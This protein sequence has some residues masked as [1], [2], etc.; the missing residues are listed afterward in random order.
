MDRREMQNRCLARLAT[1]LNRLGSGGAEV[2]F[3]TARAALQQI[4]EDLL[5]PLRRESAQIL[6]L[7]RESV[8]L[9][10]DIVDSRGI[11]A[12]CYALVTPALGAAALQGLLEAV[13]QHRGKRSEMLQRFSQEFCQKVGEHPCLHL[14]WNAWM[15]WTEEHDDDTSSLPWLLYYAWRGAGTELLELDGLQPLEELRRAAGASSA[16]NVFTAVRRAVRQQQLLA[17]VAESVARKT[18]RT[19]EGS[20]CCCIWEHREKT[21]PNG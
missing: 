6:E 19:A 2:F 10:L 16:P 13:Q 7:F 11:F 1:Q 12:S 8:E 20:S 4:L 14:P 3:P 5:Q 15:E 18:L 17:S 21:L 9:I